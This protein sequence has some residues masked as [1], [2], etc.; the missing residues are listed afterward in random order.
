MNSVDPAVAAI[1]INIDLLKEENPAA[2]VPLTMLAAAPDFE[3]APATR[4]DLVSRGLIG[5]SVNGACI[6]HDTV[7]AVVLRQATDA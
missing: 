4:D 3:M 7:R 5:V 2:M 6:M 1:Q